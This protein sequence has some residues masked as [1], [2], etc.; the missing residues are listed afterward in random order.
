[1]RRA[2]PIGLRGVGIDD[3]RPRNLVQVHDDAGLQRR[4]DALIRKG[5]VRARR[6]LSSERKVVEPHRRVDFKRLPAVCAGFDRSCDPGLE[7]EHMILRQLGGLAVE[8]DGGRSVLDDNDQFLAKRLGGIN[9][10]GLHLDAFEERSASPAEPGRH[11]RRDRNDG[12]FV[13]FYRHAVGEHH[14]HTHGRQLAR[15]SRDL[16]LIDNTLVDGCP[17]RLATRTPGEGEG[18]HSEGRQELSIA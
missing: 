13:P 6:V 16:V 17:L 12:Q 9:G 4:R 15:T 3:G 10:A 8:L 5:C 7:V 18:E 14:G 11:A 2:S 1:M